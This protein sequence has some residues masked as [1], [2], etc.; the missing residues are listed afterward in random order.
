MNPSHSHLISGGFR[1]RHLSFLGSLQNTKIWTLFAREDFLHFI[2]M[3]PSAPLLCSL[4][5]QDLC[6]ML[7]GELSVLSGNLVE[8]KESQNFEGWIFS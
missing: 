5:F 3:S 1:Q 7:L 6:C 8:L 2:E 4:R